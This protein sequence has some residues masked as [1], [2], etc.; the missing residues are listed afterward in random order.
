MITVNLYSG[1]RLYRDVCANSENDPLW[2]GPYKIIV[3]DYKWL[4]IQK[5]ASFHG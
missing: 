3:N 1:S 2:V 4:S 5:K